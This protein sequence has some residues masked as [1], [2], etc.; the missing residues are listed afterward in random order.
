MIFETQRLIVRKLGED[1]LD[2]LSAIYAD[3][4]TRRYFPDDALNREQTKEELDWFLRDVPPE[5]AAFGLRAVI[6]R[7]TGEFIGRGGLLSWTIDGKQEIE[8]AYLIAKPFWR[9]GLATEFLTALVDHAFGELH[10]TR[11]IALIDERN[12]ASIRTAEKVGF[13]FE[14]AV[15]IDGTKAQLYALN[16]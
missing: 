2:A 16:R 10:L 15:E 9:Q 13:R 1:D 4:D 14:R 12:I 8:T 7:E 11:L 6:H 5:E 3:A